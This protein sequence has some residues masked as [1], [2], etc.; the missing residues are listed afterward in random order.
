MQSPL[1]EPD[2][3]EMLNEINEINE[4]RCLEINKL[5]EKP[6]EEFF[7]LMGKHPVDVSLEAMYRIWRISVKRINQSV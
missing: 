1:Y 3:F 7:S 4:I 5:F 6:H 2:I